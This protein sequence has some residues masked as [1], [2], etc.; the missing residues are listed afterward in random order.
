MLA[1]NEESVSTLSKQGRV[2]GGILQIKERRGHCKDWVPS[3][4]QSPG[5]MRTEKNATEVSPAGQWVKDQALSL[6]WLRL[7]PR[8]R[9]DPCSCYS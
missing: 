7:L 2:P 1:E 5:W 4:M 8:H 9:V 6:Q 3:L